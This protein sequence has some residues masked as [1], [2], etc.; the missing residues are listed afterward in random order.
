MVDPGALHAQLVGRLL[1]HRR[2]CR[3]ANSASDLSA[4]AASL[5]PPPS[6]S[7]TL[8]VTASS[9]AP[10]SWLYSVNLPIVV[11]MLD[12]SVSIAALSFRRS[13]CPDSS[14]LMIAFSWA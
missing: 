9:K 6:S 11:H 12:F 10:A 2:R 3:I 7:A 4:L 8:L 1:D 14:D 13:S 5:L